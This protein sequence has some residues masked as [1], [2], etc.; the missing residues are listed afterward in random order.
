MEIVRAVLSDVNDQLL[1]VEKIS[2]GRRHFVDHIGPQRIADLTVLVLKEGGTGLTVCL[3]RRLA[4]DFTVCVSYQMPDCGCVSAG[5]SSCRG[6]VLPVVVAEFEYGSRKRC[7]AFTMV[8][9]IT[10]RILCQ[11]QVYKVCNRLLLCCEGRGLIGFHVHSIGRRVFGVSRRR[12]R[13]LYCIGP[14]RHVDGVAGP[15]LFDGQRPHGLSGRVIDGVDRAFDAVAGVAVRDAGAVACLLH[16]DMSRSFQIPDDHVL[17]AGHIADED[18][19]A[20]GNSVILGRI[21]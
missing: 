18:L 11:K 16:V 1:A 21:R 19:E 10:C 9:W 15:V 14:F 17:Y 7:V 8:V 20:V 12:C 2:G 13:F 6:A 3:D 4:A 5:F